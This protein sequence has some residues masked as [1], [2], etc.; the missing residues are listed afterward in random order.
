MRPTVVVRGLAVAAALVALPGPAT[1]QDRAA[2]IRDAR[3]GVMTHYLADWIA[4]TDTPGRPM[5]VERWNE[6]VDH[7]DMSGL[8]AQLSATGA[9]YHVLTLG[10][11]SGFY[12][13]P[14]AAYDRIVG[15]NP[16]RC[17]RR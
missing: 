11:N 9:G 16:S 8:A 7:F 17:A 3:W 6:L 1:A 2:W 12:L 13:A 15:V 14:N 4:R 5:S 10:Q